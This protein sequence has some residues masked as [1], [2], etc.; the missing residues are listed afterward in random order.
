MLVALGFAIHVLLPQLGELQQG[1]AALKTG[2]WLYLFLALVGSFMVVASSAWMVRSSVATPPSWGR[3]LGTQAAAGFSSAVTPAGLGWFAIT[4]SSLQ[5]AGTAPDEA[6]AATGLNLVLSV[7]SHVVLLVA[8]L[9]LL[10]TMQLPRISAPTWRLVVDLGVAATIAVGV[11]MW[12]PR[13]RRVLVEP[14]LS[15]VR[16]VP[17]IV[18]NPRRSGS[19]VAGAIAQN[20]SYAFVLTACLAA[21]GASTSPLAVLVV[22][23]LAATVAA[24]SPTPGGLGAMEAALIAGLTRVAVPGGEAIAAVLA[25]RL[26]TFWLVLPVGAWM[27]RVSRQ[28]AWI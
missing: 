8:V 28:R 24:V 2:R 14:V 26:A 19:M 4:Q 23:M 11:A 25:F 27:L 16:Q 13:T 7:A 20:L 21:F 10:P 5:R 1:F 18:R 22:Y 3:T 15:V 17:A 12:I 9:P 6:A